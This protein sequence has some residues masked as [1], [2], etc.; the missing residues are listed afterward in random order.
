MVDNKTKDESPETEKFFCEICAKGYKT[1]KSLRWH[2]NFT[3]RGNR[4]GKDSNVVCPICDKSFSTKSALKI[5]VAN[6]TDDGK[7]AC[8]SCGKL[9]NKFRMEI[10]MM[11]HGEKKFTCEI[12]GKKFAQPAGLNQHVQFHGEK[13]PKKPVDIAKL[14]CNICQKVLATNVSLYMHRK[15]VHGERAILCP[16]CGKS[17]GTRRALEEHKMVHTDEKPQLCKICNAT[18]KWERSY[19]GHMKRV[20]GIKQSFAPLRTYGK[21]EVV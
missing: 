2:L 12:C 15:Q 10:H 11:T 19:V 16:I 1:L 21:D 7:L 6:H 13:K 5:H 9:V 17:C 8:E 14:T 18:F 20:H 4:Q 3:H